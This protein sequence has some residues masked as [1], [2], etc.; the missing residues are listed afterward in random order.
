[1]EMI[2]VAMRRT[3]TS[4]GEEHRALVP[5]LV[6]LG[7]LVAIVSGLG[8]PLVPTIADV[9]GVS[10]STA[11]WSLTVTMLMG[12]VATPAMGRLGDGPHRR[13]VILGGLATVLAGSL[14]AALP[15][16][17]GFLI[18]GRALQ[19]VGMG[20]VP[21]AIAT[22][23]DALPPDRAR[24]ALATLSL[25]TV[26]GVGLGYPITGLL[27]QYLGMYAG[28]WF[29]L[30]AAGAALIAAALVL[31]EPPRRPA[32]PMDVPGAVLLTLGMTALLFALTEGESWGWA[33]ARLLILAAAAVLLLIGWVAHELRTPHP[34]VDVRLVRDRTVLIADLTTM[35]GGIGTYLLIS[36]VTRY[37]ETPRSTGYGFGSTVVVT[38]LVL[39]PFSAASLVSGRLVRLLARSNPLPRLL[40]LGCLLS[41][42]AM[43]CFVF[44]RGSM[45]GVCATMAVAGLGVGVNFAVT[46]ALIVGA[47]P[48]H[49]TGSAMSFNQVVKYIGYSAGSALSAVI[50]QA[51]TA[52][53]RTLPSN[54]GY[55]AAGLL[56]CAVWVVTALVG[57]ALIRRGARNPLPVGPRRPAGAPVPGRRNDRNDSTSR[58]AEVQR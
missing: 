5:V 22:A 52:P 50:L 33:S 36:L 15:L 38:G 4:S 11:Q 39:V 56:G 58:S 48:A 49:E 10:V 42:A 8:A 25:T 34:L 35:V 20:L 32:H 18:A 57:V 9:D 55:H 45:W 3:R 2:E 30:I 21:L 53:G 51:H 24:S 19:G 54:D 31:P 29:A 41:L 23:R 40:P 47:V 6:C 7:M 44:A 27:T 26:A 37:V 12:A 14:L 1:M 46:P 16:G 28:F 17:F 43:L 13:K